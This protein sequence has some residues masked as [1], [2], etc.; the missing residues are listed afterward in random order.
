MYIGQAEEHKVGP[1][2][3]RPGQIPEEHNN[4][5]SWARSARPRN[6][7]WVL[8]F[9]GHV[10]SPRNITTYVPRPGQEAKEHKVGPYIPQSGRGT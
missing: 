10:R 5:C 1:Y 9:L 6:I 4:L 3:P 8:M 7:R 2:V